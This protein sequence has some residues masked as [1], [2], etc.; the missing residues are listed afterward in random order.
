VNIIKGLRVLATT[1][2]SINGT[3]IEWADKTSKC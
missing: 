1:P 3:C 2:R